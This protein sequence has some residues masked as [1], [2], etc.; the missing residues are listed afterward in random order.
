MSRFGV[1]DKWIEQQVERT[2]A[3]P[4]DLPNLEADPYFF[5]RVQQRLSESQ[6]PQRN[7][8]ANLVW[9]YRLRPVLLAAAI[10]VNLATV[11]FAVQSASRTDVREQY[12]ESISSQYSVDVTTLVTENS[13]GQ[14]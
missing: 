3:C 10:V 5:G 9:G 8:I 13:D 12:I 4:H 14:S 6:E 2:L 11:L 7:W 1:K